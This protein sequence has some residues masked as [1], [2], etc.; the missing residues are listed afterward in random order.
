MQSNKYSILVIDD[1]EDL[2]SVMAEVLEI[3]GYVVDTAISG[4]LALQKLKEKEY[5]C[6]DQV[7]IFLFIQCCPGY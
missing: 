6:Y 5:N 2:L 1:D 3:G 7:R 4:D